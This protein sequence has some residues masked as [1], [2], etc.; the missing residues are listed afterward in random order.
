MNCDEDD[1]EPLDAF[2]E[3]VFT[4]PQSIV[5]IGYNVLLKIKKE[6]QFDQS[7]IEQQSKLLV[8]RLVKSGLNITIDHE[9]ASGLL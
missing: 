2:P 1:F 9:L 7:V 8:N 6:T 4:N 3:Y 5:C